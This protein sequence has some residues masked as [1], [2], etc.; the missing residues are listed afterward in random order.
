LKK[1]YIKQFNRLKKNANIEVEEHK[2]CI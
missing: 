2:I 1:N